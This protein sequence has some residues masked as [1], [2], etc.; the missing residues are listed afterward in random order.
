MRL[1]PQKISNFE[2][3]LR[4]A[5][6]R[7]L[8]T[9]IIGNVILLTLGMSGHQFGVTGG[10]YFSHT[11]V[12][13]PY[14]GTLFGITN[15]MAQIPG[16]ANALIVGILTPNGTR[17]EWLLV[18]DIASLIFVFG[19]L[20]YCLCGSSDLQYWAKGKNQNSDEMKKLDSKQNDGLDIQ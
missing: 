15:T 10:Y 6:L 3:R 8:G 19:C 18:F 5:F 4:L 20:T 16:F 12:A 2:A 1:K 11:D 13:G 17:E 14:S 9:L 7:F